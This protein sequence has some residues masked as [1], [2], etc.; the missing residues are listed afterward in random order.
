[1]CE[2]SWWFNNLSMW[3]S[4][5]CC[6]V[7]LLLLQRP[8]LSVSMR[9]ASITCDLHAKGVHRHIG[10]SLAKGLGLYLQ[11]IGYYDPLFLDWQGSFKDPRPVTP[12]WWAVLLR[13]SLRSV[14]AC[15]K[16]GPMVGNTTCSIGPEVRIK[17]NRLFDVCFIWV[18][19]RG[20]WP[21][22]SPYEGTIAPN[23]F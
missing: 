15:H 10:W 2:W 18:V 11:I 19:E 16:H 7:L 14:F 9:R 13:L 23:R 21:S 6:H 22:R 1:M 17:E 5:S 20:V 4:Y 12:I 8:G 3:S